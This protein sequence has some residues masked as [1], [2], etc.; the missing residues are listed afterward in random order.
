MTWQLDGSGLLVYRARGRTARQSDL[1]GMCGDSACAR[2]VKRIGAAPS[3]NADETRSAIREKRRERLSRRAKR[4]AKA[5]ARRM[6]VRI[7]AAESKPGA[8]RSARRRSERAWLERVAPD[9]Y[10]VAPMPNE[11]SKALRRR[12][13]DVLYGF[14]RP[15]VRHCLPETINP[16]RLDP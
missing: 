2:M 16:E 9:L 7:L 8:N 4:H 11:P 12:C 6:I 10:G 13:Q 3:C 5:A 15:D 1:S 14:V